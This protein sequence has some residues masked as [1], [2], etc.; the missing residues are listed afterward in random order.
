ML[1]AEQKAEERAGKYSGAYFMLVRATQSY[2]L[3][4]I[5][6]I[7]LMHN[8]L[9]HIIQNPVVWMHRNVD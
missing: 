7:K 8:K 4:N 9:I 5:T 2:S 3:N 1:P 6:G